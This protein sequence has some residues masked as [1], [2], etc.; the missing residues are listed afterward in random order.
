[1]PAGAHAAP[2]LASDWEQ[3]VTLLAAIR[4]DGK[5]VPPMFSLKGVEGVVPRSNWPDAALLARSTLKQVWFRRLAPLLNIPCL[6][7]SQSVSVRGVHEAHGG[8]ACDA[9]SRHPF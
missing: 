3:H 9:N 7:R 5:S 8:Q 1:V 2:A 6:L 4:A